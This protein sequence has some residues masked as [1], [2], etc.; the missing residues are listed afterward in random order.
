MMRQSSTRAR[1]T[2]A[3]TYATRSA[4]T[5]DEGRGCCRGVREDT[6]TATTG[7]HA[8]EPMRE[9]AGAD[10]AGETLGL[11]LAPSLAPESAAGALSFTDA[12][13]GLTTMAGTGADV[14]ARVTRAVADA[15]VEEG[16]TVGSAEPEAHSVLVEVADDEKEVGMVASEG[17]GLEEAVAKVG[18]RSFAVADGAPSEHVWVFT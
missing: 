11:A 1:R 9:R 16:A 10:N 14:G 13:D 12:I 17:P 2:R 6:T 4:N 18:E 15:E 3:K 8:P 7:T 5:P